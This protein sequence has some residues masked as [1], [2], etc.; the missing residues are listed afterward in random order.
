MNDFYNLEKQYIWYFS[1][2][3]EPSEHD[4][5]NYRTLGATQVDCVGVNEPFQK[6]TPL[7]GRITERPIWIHIIWS[8]ILF[9]LL[10][11]IW[12]NQKSKLEFSI[13]Q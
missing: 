7:R 11:F 1:R 2:V 4:G 9:H 12:V 6:K 5:A 10:Y 3:I 8:R 13:T